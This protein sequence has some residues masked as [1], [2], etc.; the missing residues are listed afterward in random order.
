M[1]GKVKDCWDAFKKHDT[2]VIVHF[3]GNMGSMTEANIARAGKAFSSEKLHVEFTDIEQISQYFLDRKTPKIDREFTVEGK[4]YFERSDKNLRGMVCSVEAS[5]IIR[6][7]ESEQDPKIIN[8][9]VFDANVR[10]FLK[11]TNRINKKIIESIVSDDNHMFWYKNNGITITCDQFKQGPTTKNPKIKLKNMQIVNGGQ[12]LNCLFEA[13]LDANVDLDDVL[14]LVRIIETD[15]EEIKLSIA[16]TT[17]SQTP[18]NVRD[19]RANDTSQKKLEEAFLVQGLFY[20]RKSNQYAEK[21]KDKRVDALDAGQAWLAYVESPETAKRNRGMVFG[22][23]CDKIFTDETEVKHL[24]VPYLLRMEIEN[25]KTSLRKKIKEKKGVEPDD[26]YLID[27]A[28][29]VLFAIFQVA[30]NDGLDPFNYEEVKK[31][32]PIGMNIVREVY[33]SERTQ[34]ET[35]SS[36]RLFKDSKTKSLIIKKV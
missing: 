3:C 23:L 29:H 26:M 36:N 6:I 21:P 24:L 7:I 28:F 2:E 14:V 19:L 1:A 18:I 17:N 30:Q 8:P 15:D 10:I 25:E 31:L 11:R 27:G 35:F 12:T 9:D 22:D 5:E 34:D 33:S 4:N 20:E 13:S 32:I 16:E